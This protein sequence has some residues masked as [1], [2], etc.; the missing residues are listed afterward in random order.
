VSHTN[1]VISDRYEEL[2]KRIKMLEAERDYYKKLCTEKQDKLENIPQSI[3][4]WGYVEIID[5]NE[6]IKLILEVASNE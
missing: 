5:N 1:I 3:K 2:Y 6:T 4:D